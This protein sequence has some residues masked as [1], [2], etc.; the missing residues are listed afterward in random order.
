MIINLLVVVDVPIA[1]AG[2]PP[3]Q[4]IAIRIRPESQ[5][6]VSGYSA[7]FKV[8]LFSQSGFEGYV[9]LMIVD[10]PE[11]ITAV[12]TP[13]PAYVP[14]FDETETVMTIN[15]ASSIAQRE[16]NITVYAQCAIVPKCDDIDSEIITL[17]MT[18]PISS[19]VT[20]TKTITTTTTYS[21]TLRSTNTVTEIDKITEPIIYAWAVGA[22]IIVA[23]LGFA[24][25]W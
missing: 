10:P 11:G 3:G 12:F 22:T 18:S 5:E 25:I 7:S 9:F 1:F 16:V 14:A 24:I 8:E 2:E 19:E 6:I 17:N 4:D 13:N 23:I 21:T 20:F 15:L